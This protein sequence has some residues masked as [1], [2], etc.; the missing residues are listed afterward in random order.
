MYEIYSFKSDNEENNSK[1]INDPLEYRLWR[2]WLRN[3]NEEE[4]L[5]IVS[6]YSARNCYK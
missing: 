5:T 3:N 6:S 2:K 1:F 4:S